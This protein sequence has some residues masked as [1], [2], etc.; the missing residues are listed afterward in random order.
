MGRRGSVHLAL[1]QIE[2]RELSAQ[3][4]ALLDIRPDPYPTSTRRTLSR[5]AEKVAAARGVQRL[6]LPTLHDHVARRLTGAEGG[7]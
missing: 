6:S 3:L 2:A 4:R 1:T 5:L 7:K